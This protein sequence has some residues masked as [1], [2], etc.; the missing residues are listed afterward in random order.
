MD[1][2]RFLESL[3]VVASSPLALAAYAIL[4]CAW[5]IRIWIATEPE[6]QVKSILET[7]KDDTNRLS[8]LRAL[9]GNDIPKGLPRNEILKIA[10]LRAKERS[11]SLLLVAYVA[12]LATFILITGMAFYR[13]GPSQNN[14]PPEL[15]DSTAKVNRP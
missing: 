10:K 1:V 5:V 13:I 7:Y 12:S 14:S 9:L 4:V 11:H 2:T 8:A 3:R 6:R 15:I